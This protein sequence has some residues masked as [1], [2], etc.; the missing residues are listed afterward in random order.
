M[1]SNKTYYLLSSAV[2]LLPIILGL[3]YYSALPQA[4]AVHWDV[5]GQPDNYV[6]KA[7][8]VFGLPVLMLAINLAVNIVS[9]TRAGYPSAMRALLGWMIPSL[10]IVIYAITVCSALGRNIA[11]Y[12]IV[13]VI[14]GI[15]YVA[16]GNY[17]PK[18]KKNGT[19]GIRTSRSM[20]S[21]ENWRR[22]NRFGGYCFVVCGLL[23][24]VLSLL[25]VHY[26]IILAVLVIP[27]LLPIFY[28]YSLRE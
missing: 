4:I 19:L 25:R 10:N 12:V 24:I 15:F 11:I 17:L 27:A 28:S 13:P 5:S 9:H 20:S 23:I 16:M 18:V 21:D 26:L 6:S 22:S 1:K 7:L 14:V 3:A 8:A 2:C